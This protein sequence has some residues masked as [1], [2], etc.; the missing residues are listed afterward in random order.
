LAVTAHAQYLP[1]PC[2]FRTRAWHLLDHTAAA[3]FG[4]PGMVSGT[5]RG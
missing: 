2:L 1:F 5:P 3:H 4:R